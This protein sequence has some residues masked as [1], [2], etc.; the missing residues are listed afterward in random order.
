M[1][2]ERLIAEL[3]ASHRPVADPRLRVGA[4]IGAGWLA[5]LAGMLVFFGAPLQEL[6][7]T[8]IAAFGIKIGYTFAL[9]AFAAMAAIAAGRPGRRLLGPVM[10]IAMPAIILALIAILEFSAATE[11]GRAKMIAGT[12]YWDCVQSVVLASV[13]VFLGMVWA[14]RILA[15]TRLPLAGFLVGL[16]AGAAGAM[17]F[18]LYCHEASAAFLLAA[19][20]PAMLV[21]AFIGAIAARPLFR[22]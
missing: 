18:S 6:R 8:G 7:H 11:S 2:T 17:A 15:P 3:A 16:S 1:R 4:A 9:A 20:T 12:S 5:A 21:P 14:Y 19:Y 22:W 10:L 13:P